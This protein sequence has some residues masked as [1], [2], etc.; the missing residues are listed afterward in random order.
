MISKSDQP[1]ATSHQPH[2]PTGNEM[3]RQTIFDCD[4]HVF[5]PLEVWTKYLDPEYRVSARTSFWY[6]PDDRGLPA[7][8]LNG[9]PGRPLSSNGIN[10]QAIWR[11]GMKP[12]DI[13]ALDPKR[14]HAIN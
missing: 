10:R 4:S 1:P 14:H 13:G 5:E 2:A 9:R 11:P 6:E 7:V 8:I 3:T 12:E